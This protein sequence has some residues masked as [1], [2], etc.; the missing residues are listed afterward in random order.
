M[1]EYFLILSVVLMID[2]AGCGVKNK[3]HNKMSSLI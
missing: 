2:E 3:L 1:D